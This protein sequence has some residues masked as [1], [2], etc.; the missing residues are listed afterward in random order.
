MKREI[1]NLVKTYPCC[2]GHDKFPCETYSSNRSKRARA[3][4][5]KKEHQVVRRIQ[6][7]RLDKELTELSV[8]E[9]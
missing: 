1:L 3:R 8:Q 2:P 4:D 7:R 5:I 6:R 9:P